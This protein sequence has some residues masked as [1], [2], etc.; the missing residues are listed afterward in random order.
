MAA[1]VCCS[2]SVLAVSAYVPYLLV[3]YTQTVFQSF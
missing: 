3:L 2:L 1:D